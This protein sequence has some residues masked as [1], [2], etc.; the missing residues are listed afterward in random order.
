MI[1][2]LLGVII[3]LL[4]PLWEFVWLNSLTQVKLVLVGVHV[5][6]LLIQK[7]ILACFV[8]YKSFVLFKSSLIICLH[9]PK[10]KKKKKIVQ[11]KIWVKARFEPGVPYT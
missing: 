6:K 4:E 11:Q 9:F 3:S 8:D 7:L 1:D 5:C 10:K 2:S